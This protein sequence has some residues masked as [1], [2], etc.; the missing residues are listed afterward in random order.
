MIR[1]R[2]LFFVLIFCCSTHGQIN[3]QLQILS[4][5]EMPKIRALL[6]QPLT[7]ESIKIISNQLAQA[8][9]KIASLENELPT[10]KEKGNP[11]LPGFIDE[12]KK[13]IES[14]ESSFTIQK[15]A[16][17]PMHVTDE[18][19]TVLQLLDQWNTY[20]FN[21]VDYFASES[22]NQQKGLNIIAETQRKKN[23]A[24]LSSWYAKAT[25]IVEEELKSLQNDLFTFQQSYQE[26]CNKAFNDIMTAMQQPPSAPKRTSSLV[27][28]QAPTQPILITE[29]APPRPVEKSAWEIIQEKAD[30]LGRTI[31]E[32]T[33]AAMQDAHKLS[34]P[35]EKRLRKPHSPEISSQP[36]AEQHAQTTYQQGSINA[37]AQSAKI[38]T[39]VDR[40]YESRSVYKILARHGT[41]GTMVHTY[42]EF[43]NL[44][45][46][47][48]TVDLSSI[49]KME[50]I[51]N[52]IVLQLDKTVLNIIK[53]QKQISLKNEDE[54]NVYHTLFVLPTIFYSMLISKKIA[55]I[56]DEAGHFYQENK[57]LLQEHHQKTYTSAGLLSEKE[58]QQCI[59][60]TVK[61]FEDEHLLTSVEQIKA[62]F[63][64]RTIRVIT[65]TDTMIQNLR[66]KLSTKALE[67]VLSIKNNI[68]SFIH[69]S[70]FRSLQSPFP[71]AKTLLTD[72]FIRLS[73]FKDIAPLLLLHET[74]TTFPLWTTEDYK[75]VDL[76]KIAIYNAFKV[77]TQ[78][79]KEKAKKENNLTEATLLHEQLER[80]LTL[81]RPYM[82][83]KQPKQSVTRM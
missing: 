59:T 61:L 20:K 60:Y 4:K 34:S 78:K 26:N 58:K 42:M 1:Q 36:F 12:L 7:D 29:Q 79:A 15:T 81:I 48:F 18:S 71:I 13:N 62:Y 45:K 27:S 10:S 53:N 56:S 37:P 55:W 5:E 46:I 82:G 70:L 50:K 65:R 28:E 22:S 74:Q 9:A 77:C 41:T 25:K 83:T 19:H 67:F 16:L 68:L 21:S 69:V 54:G 11:F 2:F 8:K 52:T 38:N 3:E 57:K 75:Q 63:F 76:A 73:E 44:P 31:K 80:I 14:L 66:K 32:K 6:L 24:V 39:L 72:L 40:M 43:I 23:E 17:K 30:Q 47:A 51:A 49:Q 64:L 35:I 33:K